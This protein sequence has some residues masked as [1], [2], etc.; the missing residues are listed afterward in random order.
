MRL[1]LPGADRNKPT[2]TDAIAIVDRDGRL[3]VA[4]DAVLPMYSLT[5][6]FIAA[7]V[8][9]LKIDL[10]ELIATWIDRCWAPRGAEIT[11]QHLL[12]H[13]SGLRDY[14]GLSA[15]H[16]AVRAGGAV[17]S[18][19]TFADHTLRQPLL[20]EPGVGWAYSNPGYWLLGQIAQR[21]TGLDLA[22][23]FRRTIVEPLDLRSI[24]L[25]RGVFSDALPNYPA[26]WVWHGLLLASAADVARFMA[27]DLAARLAQ[28]IVPVPGQHVGWIA[29]HY[30]Y[31]VMVE[32]GV[33]YGHLGGGP[34]FSAACFKFI[35]N[36]RTICVLMQ[37][38]QE[39]AAHEHLL[40]LAADGS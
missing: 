23:V 24:R 35:A 8:V 5:K 31:G 37:S 19:E 40:A 30:G 33:R 16:D 21:E 27:S 26:E 9:A 12:Q 7:A 11:V 1:M 36:G 29:P 22:G 6:T 25:A 18:D 13:T 38:E 34:S 20:F 15:Y 17:W 28:H 10:R 32:P 3:D 39:G 4:A 14:G 2:M